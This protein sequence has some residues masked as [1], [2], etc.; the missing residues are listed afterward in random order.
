MASRGARTPMRGTPSRSGGAAAARGAKETAVA[1]T[2]DQRNEIKEA[3]ELFDTDRSGTI[4]YHELKVAMRALGFPVKKA[5]VKRILAEVDTDGSG[6]IELP[7]FMRIMEEKFQSRDPDEEV[8]KAFKLFDDD[9]TGRISL[10]NMQRV[11]RELG[12]DLNDD[13]MLAMIEEF[14]RDQDGEINEQEFAYIMKQTSI[15]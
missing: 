8:W 10:K 15:Y 12:E 1:L 6:T 3:F 7:E 4:D 14:D 9:D 11:A 5:E 2:E 13:E